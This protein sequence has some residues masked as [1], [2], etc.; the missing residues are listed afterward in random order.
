MF[1]TLSP[2][3]VPASPVALGKESMLSPDPLSV[4]DNIASHPA[5]PACDGAHPSQTSPYNPEP[6]LLSRLTA[7]NPRPGCHSSSSSVGRGL[8]L[9]IDS[10]CCW[11]LSDAEFYNFHCLWR[12]KTL[13]LA[14]TKIKTQQKPSGRKLLSKNYMT[15]EARGG[16]KGE[17]QVQL[18]SRQSRQW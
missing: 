9:C 4:T 1:L 14:L 8:S 13:A 18:V 10:H 3:H 11:L 17:K 5:L 6:F 2:Q 7:L 15:L 16:H 12:T